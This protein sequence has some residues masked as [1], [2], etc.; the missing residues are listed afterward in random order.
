MEQFARKVQMDKERD[1]ELLQ[2]SLARLAAVR[3]ETPGAYAP[4]SCGAAG[5]M[6]QVLRYFK[7]EEIELPEHLRKMEEQLDYVLGQTGLLSRPIVLRG[8]WWRNSGEPLVGLLQDEAVMVML[9]PRPLG[10]YRFIDPLSGK[11]EKVSGRN[12]RRF[13]SG[14]TCFYRP[15]PA[16]PMGIRQL[17]VHMAGHIAPF[18]LI[19]MLLFSAAV[20][21]AGLVFPLMNRMIFHHI[22]PSGSAADIWPV[23][24]LLLG[25]ALSSI[26][27][28]LAK[29]L[30]LAGMGDKIRTGAQ[31]ALWDRVLNLSPQFFKRYSSG[32]LLERIQAMGRFCDVLTGNAG[33]VLLTVVFSFSY[34]YQISLFSP[35]LLGPALFVSAAM[36][37]FSAVVGLTEARHQRSISSQSARLSGLLF[38]FI[39]GMAKIKTAGAQERAFAKWAEQYAKKADTVY[40]PPLLLPFANGIFGVLGIASS[41]LIYQSAIRHSI[42]PADFIAFHVAFGAFTGTMAQLYGVVR[43]AATFRSSYELLR[44]LLQEAP[45]ATAR[46]VKT[47]RLSGKIEL[48][49]VSFRYAPGSPLI[50][51]EL[52]LTVQPGE[53]VA[54]VGASGSGKSTL[55][56][57]LLGFELPS[58]GAVYYDDQDLARLD[59]RSV[60]GRIGAVLQN[61]TLFADSIFANL[62]VCAPGLTMEQAWE[63]AE[64]AGIA[65]DIRRMPMGMLTMISEGGGGISGGQKQRLIIARVFA[66]RPDIILLDEATSALDNRSQSIIVESLEQLS[67]TRIVIAHRLSTVRRCNRI[68]VLDRG[69]VLEEGS[70]DSLMRD[71]GYFARMARRQLV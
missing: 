12:C 30:Q 7:L 13:A 19:L 61:G 60:R 64:Q 17:A 18:E 43:Q 39:S 69:R 9:K 65:D 46:G 37:I 22:I 59:M 14:A 38:Q 33:S 24:A 20:V 57:L 45:E 36:L 58:G 42:A 6:N 47:D 1:K 49:G 55:M 70:Y 26:A 41:L 21:L 34:L 10:G 66:A 68:I 48:A 2:A 4:D 16:E 5:A 32:E 50:L 3:G 40:S 8:R 62:A 52:S 54:L 11:E 28:A 53:Y 56:R 63:A 71:N 25:A 31:N 27:F 35:R 67:V 44:P 15:F 23:A 29:S 51:D